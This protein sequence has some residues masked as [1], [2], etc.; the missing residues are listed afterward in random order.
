[1]ISVKCRWGLFLLS[2]SVMGA[3]PATIADPILSAQQAFEN[4]DYSEAV[5][6]YTLALKTTNEPS[7]I[8]FNLGIVHLKQSQWALAE[9]HFRQCLSDDS[10]PKDRRAR[11]WYNLGICILK[12]DSQ[13]LKRLSAA[14][15]YFEL[16]LREAREQNGNALAEDAADNLEIARM[17]WLKTL[18]EKQGDQPIPDSE[19][20]NP[21]PMKKTPE[22]KSKEDPVD[23]QPQ[24]KDSTTQKGNLE[25]VPVPKDKKD[26]LPADPKESPLK[27]P[28][29][30]S[31]PVLPDQANQKIEL[32]PEQTQEYLRQAAE[33]IRSERQKIRQQSLSADR[34]RPNDW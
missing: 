28:S 13:N 32:S 11:A 18:R 6:L 4:R 31:L 19:K 24:K 5:R 27:K 21:D 7:W 10:L 25:P 34:L 23:S 17:L 30:G 22:P 26:T 3:A 15:E 1:M 29:K 8:S 9:S 33:R 12:Q 20:P 16:A 2:G 14:A